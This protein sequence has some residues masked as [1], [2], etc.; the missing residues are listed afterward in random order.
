MGSLFEFIGTLLW[1]G[2]LSLMMSNVSCDVVV[3]GRMV[4]IFLLG[5]IVSGVGILMMV[6]E[7]EQIKVNC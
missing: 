5:G 6:G 3:V 1:C 7:L 2:G 4:G